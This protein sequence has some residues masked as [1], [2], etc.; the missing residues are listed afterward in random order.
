M[1]QSYTKRRRLLSEPPPPGPESQYLGGQ[2]SVTTFSTSTA[3]VHPASRRPKSEP[4][5][6]EEWEYHKP[7]ICR[8]YVQEELKLQ[9]VM[10]EMKSKY[11]F[12]ASCVLRPSFYFSVDS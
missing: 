10:K 12:N 3:S 9:D 7:N 6:D 2:P 11:H 8:L 1:E 5:T 4:K